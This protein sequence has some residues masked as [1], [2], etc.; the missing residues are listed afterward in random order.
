MRRLIFLDPC[1]FR[2]QTQPGGTAERR[3]GAIVPVDISIGE[4]GA[5]GGT[6][7][8]VAI[9]DLSVRNRALVDAQQAREQL[10]AQATERAA[11]AKDSI[12]QNDER[13]PPARPSQVLANM[14]HEIR[15]PMNRVWA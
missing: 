9:A 5:A 11:L 15:T 12:T 10:E 4:F 6:I 3:D 13:R 7:G 1:A 8:V 2:R 14:S